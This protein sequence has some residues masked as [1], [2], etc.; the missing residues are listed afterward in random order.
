MFSFAVGESAG[1]GGIY[2]AA[3]I[4]KS[5]GRTEHAVC[6]TIQRSGGGSGDWLSELLYWTVQR[7]GV[8]AKLKGNP[9]EYENDAASRCTVRSII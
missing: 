3:T 2:S 5:L 4:V 1:G 6:E 7:C 9:G 8:I